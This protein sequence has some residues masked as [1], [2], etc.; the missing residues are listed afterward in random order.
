M[1]S[2]WGGAGGREAHDC[3]ATP[4]AQPHSVRWLNAGFPE[5][6]E[7]VVGTQPSNFAV[8]ATLDRSRKRYSGQAADVHLRF[9]ERRKC[10]HPSEGPGSCPSAADEDVALR[11]WSRTFDVVYRAM[12]AK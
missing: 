5:D 2:K 7:D 12:F 1:G 9:T 6:P 10:L 4:I 11:F 8:P 3:S